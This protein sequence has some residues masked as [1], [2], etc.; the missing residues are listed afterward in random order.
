M[1]NGPNIEIQS[2]EVRLYRSG[3]NGTETTLI[4]PEKGIPMRSFTY[5]NT[6]KVPSTIVMHARHANGQDAWETLIRRT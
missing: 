6:P 3:P 4:D 2:R 5:I 1:E